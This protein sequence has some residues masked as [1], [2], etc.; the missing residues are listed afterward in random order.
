LFALFSLIPGA[1]LF[2][3][4]ARFVFIFVLSACVLAGF[5]LEKILQL[6]LSPGKRKFLPVIAIL[7]LVSVLLL[8]FLK[9]VAIEVGS[10]IALQKFTSSPRMD[11]FLSQIPLVFEQIFIDYFFAVTSISLFLFL[12]YLKLKGKISEKKVTV[13]LT[14]F[15]FI[16][17]FIY[18]SAFIQPKTQE[19]YFT[20]TP[21][22]KFLQEN[23]SDYRILVLDQ[24]IV[25]NNILYFYGIEQMLGCESTI[26]ESF[27]EYVMKINKKYVAEDLNVNLTTDILPDSDL[28]I[29]KNLNT[30]YILSR[31]EIYNNDLYLE[32]RDENVFVYRLD[33]ARKKAFFDSSESQA[34]VEIKKLNENHYL[35]KTDNSIKTPLVFS[36][37]Y[38]PGWKVFIDGKQEELL[39]YEN[40]LMMVIV[41]SGSHRVEFV[42]ESK[43][44]F[45]GLFISF[46]SFILSLYLL[47]FKRN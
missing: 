23:S 15:I 6:K 38:F 3:A 30:K 26:D 19:E 20:K 43:E 4:P 17:L 34:S 1:E 11:Y 44:F 2:R 9:P 39:K 36:M 8:F 25:S 37:A 40:T 22:I 27:S 14:A 12:F 5:G 41:P 33:G 31:K 7:L 16:N 13:I 28:N 18:G 21:L 29:L 32:F 47:F 35:V 45:F 42:F 10:N 24:T 46:F